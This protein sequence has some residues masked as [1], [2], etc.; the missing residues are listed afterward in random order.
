MRSV[1]MAEG[2]GSIW[3]LPEYKQY[4]S[5]FRAKAE[6]LM[7]RRRYYDGTV[8]NDTN[9]MLG[10]L[11]YRVG[12]EIKPLFLPL[13]RAVDIDAG[14]V[15]G[16]WRML[17]EDEGDNQPWVDAR[18]VL[19]SWSEWGTD[20]VLFVHYGAQYGMSGLKV[21]DLRERVDGGRVVMKPVD[22]TNYI[23]IGEG[24]M[25]GPAMAIWVETKMEGGEEHEYA[26]VITPDW[27]YTYWDGEPSGIGWVNEEGETEE[28]WPNELGFV[29][30]VEVHHIKTGEPYGEAT[31]EKAMP[32]LDEVNA[33]ASDLSKIIKDH[34]EPQW[35][36]IGAEPS[37]LEHS[38]ENV[39]FIPE[40][41]DVKVLLPPIDIPG[42]LDFIREIKDGVKEAMPELS[43]DELRSKDQIAAE[44][45]GLQLI[46]LVLKVKRIRPNYD[47][48]LVRAL[49]M[50][51]L[52][53]LSMGL[54][55][56]VALD[57]DMLAMDANREVL[58]LDQMTR[59]RLEQAQLMLDREKAGGIREGYDEG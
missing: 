59:I 53:G 5:M 54:S 14:I 17:G 13:S 1:V 39:W 21:S 40:G 31:F 49:R 36:V 57:D 58:P 20:G 25:G 22:P 45:L 46:E 15:P 28:G 4:L 34:N 8:Y 2:V 18:D 27:I 29:P 35:A 42:V 16:G 26:E 24:P 7:R 32:L 3:E 9:E 56:I 19:F 55:E 11:R 52:A 38:G 37:D 12:K 51:G 6:K 44:T 23:L 50:A 48:G 33:M 47:D 30:F 43:F 10:W 41:G